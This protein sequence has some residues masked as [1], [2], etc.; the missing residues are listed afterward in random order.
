MI[1]DTLHRRKG[2]CYNHIHSVARDMSFGLTAVNKK[3]FSDFLNIILGCKKSAQNSTKRP[4][5]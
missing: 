4:I 1:G 2:I 5:V 3:L